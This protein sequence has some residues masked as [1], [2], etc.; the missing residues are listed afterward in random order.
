M[1]VAAYDEGMNES[2]SLVQED[3][4]IIQVQVHPQVLSHAAI[5]FSRR[6]N[7]MLLTP[8]VPETKS[9]RS[10][11]RNTVRFLVFKVQGLALLCEPGRLWWNDTNITRTHKLKQLNGMYYTICDMSPWLYVS[12]KN[13][14][15]KWALQYKKC[16]DRPWQTLTQLLCIKWQNKETPASKKTD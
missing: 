3:V 10:F 9:Y 13:G 7:L 2:F 11:S 5:S 1:P 8:N 6:E 12:H 16:S 14:F 15:S 4:C